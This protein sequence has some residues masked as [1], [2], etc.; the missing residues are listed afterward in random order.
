M[1]RGKLGKHREKHKILNA[2]TFSNFFPPDMCESA[3]RTHNIAKGLTIN[4]VK[5][6]WQQDFPTPNE[7]MFQNTR[8]EKLNRET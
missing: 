4:N 1:V 2:H 5:V 3:T 8:E 7:G 6:T